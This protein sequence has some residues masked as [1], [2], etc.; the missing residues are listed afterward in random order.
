MADSL[1][2]PVADII[3]RTEYALASVRLLR[4]RSP[5]CSQRNWYSG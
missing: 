4:R 3:S 2:L 5:E 1:T